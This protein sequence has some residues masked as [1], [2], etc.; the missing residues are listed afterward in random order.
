MVDTQTEESPVSCTLLLVTVAA[1]LVFSVAWPASSGRWCARSWW[2][3]GEVPG[4]GRA[5]GTRWRRW[6]LRWCH[7]SLTS[8][9]VYTGCDALEEDTMGHTWVSWEVNIGCGAECELSC[10]VCSHDWPGEILRWHGQW[11]LLS[12]PRHHPPPARAQDPPGGSETPYTG[13]ARPPSATQHSYTTWT[14]WLGQTEDTQDKH[15][16]SVTSQSAQIWTKTWNIDQSPAM[17]A[18]RYVVREA[19]VPDTITL[20][21]VTPGWWTDT[22]H[23]PP[24]PPPPPPSSLLPVTAARLGHVNCCHLSARA[25]VC[26]HHGNNQRSSTASQ[27]S[28][29]W[30]SCPSAK[31]INW[32]Y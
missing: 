25:D 5:G 22:G 15:R 1:H 29:P 3:E 20:G 6:R 26:P 31:T 10:P 23:P 27:P 13:P 18:P 30:K 7:S 24:L 14:W 17:A 2:V 16:P 32:E 11:F 8:W 19:A 9:H 12:G 21:P 28:Q 4:W